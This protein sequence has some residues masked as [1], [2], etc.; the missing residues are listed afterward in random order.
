MVRVLLARSTKV[1]NI[2]KSKYNLEDIKVAKKFCQ[3][4]IEYGYEV[5][6]NF[7]CGDIIN[8]DEIEL[9]A[10]EFHDM[11]HIKALYL[12]DTYGGFNTTNVPKQLHKFYTEFEKYNSKIS[13]GFHSHNNNEDV[14]N[15]TIKAI[16][17]GCSII[18]SCIYGLGRG[19]GNLKTEQYLSYRYRNYIDK[20][21]D[22]I[23][24]II[25]YI[26]KH[27]LS[28]KEYCNN[29]YILSHPYYMISSV[30]SLHPNYI[31]EILQMNNSVE[32]DI[33][34]IKKLDKYT[35]TNNIIHSTYNLYI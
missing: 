19:S 17:H 4:L 12:A 2:H 7:G 13:F 14:L 11:D 35:K 1:N 25:V 8:D 16:Y 30:L 18:D 31:D 27:V 24:P 34:L 32:D 9:I 29:R 26:E 15:K 28:K 20:Y 22:I 3:D 5:R 21:F 6:I 10:S 33:K 23:M